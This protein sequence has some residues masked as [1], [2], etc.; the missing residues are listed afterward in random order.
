MALRGRKEPVER[1]EDKTVEINAQMQGSL[2]FKDPVN[3]KINGEFNGSL[4]TKGTLSVGSRAAVD[5][6]I[7][8]DNIIIAGKVNGNITAHKMLTLMP[9]AVLKGDI[10][11]SKLNVVEGAIFQGRCQ[12]MDSTLA[13][14]DDLLDIDEVAKYLE[15]DLN[16]IESLAN[17]GKIRLEWR[18]TIFLDGNLKSQNT[19]AGN[20]DS[21]LRA[22]AAF[23]CAVDQGKAIEFHNGIFA[24]QPANEG[25][26]FS[27]AQLMSIAQANMDAT[28]LE[29]FTTCMTN[30]DYTSWVQNSYDAFSK[31]GVTK[32][33]RLR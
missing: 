30:G 15:I 28:Q 18:P 3:L 23:G 29:A 33:P 19:A 7:T 13:T 11:T 16:E 22:T 5:A 31:E 8:G 9:T 20:A 1:D 2:K 14:M 27:D 24:A 10:S 12:M 4:D 26:G 6:D 21:S 25:E 17:S 32:S